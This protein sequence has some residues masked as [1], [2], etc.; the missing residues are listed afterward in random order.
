VY[1]EIFKANQLRVNFR[2]FPTK[3]YNALSHRN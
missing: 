1:G 3:R 2:V